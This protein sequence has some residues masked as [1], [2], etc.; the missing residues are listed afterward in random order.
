MKIM[1]LA[2]NDVGLYQFRKELIEEL[3]KQHEVVISLPYGDFVKPLEDIGCKFIDTPVDRRG[4]N[5]IKDLRLFFAYWKILKQEKPD[6]VITYTIKPNVYGGC[7]CR[8]IKI[9]YAVN[10]TGLG[11]AF[12]NAG[13]LKKI[14]T[15]MYK[16]G[17][18]KAKVVF[19][20]NE[21]NR[22]IFIQ[23]KIVK[24]SQ[25]HRL[26]GAGVNLEKYQVAPYPDGEKLKF[27]FMGRIMAEK[28]IDELFEAMHHLVSDGIN[29]ELNL[30]GFY[31]ENYKEKIEKYQAEG[32]LNYYG[33]QK[34]VKPFIEDSHCFVL[35]SWHEG[36]ANT[37][38]ECAAMGRPVI[39]SSIHGC[40]EAVEDGVSGYLCEKQ[41]ADD[42]Y[43][44]MKKFAMLSYDD[45]KNMGLA[46]R[47]RMEDIFDK[48]KVVKETLKELRI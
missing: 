8:L 41:N 35:P 20:E 43:R 25:T 19:F 21:G 15:F 42:L 6:L 23:E 29:C 47:R 39:T 48:K 32:W 5:P 10:I 7:I 28:G 37:N 34:D 46:G 33:Y 3:L 36:M 45:K 17:C 11:T 24:Q 13:M 22:Q 40:M 14:V 1:I 30:L 38:L 27:L 12:E 9:P 26:N 4:M 44:T 31:E 18:K 16:V 2:N